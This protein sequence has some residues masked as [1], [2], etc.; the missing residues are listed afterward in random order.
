MKYGLNVHCP[1]NGEAVEVNAGSALSL[2]ATVKETDDPGG[3]KAV[4]LN[5]GSQQCYG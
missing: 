3:G 5:I 2:S 1:A 4:P